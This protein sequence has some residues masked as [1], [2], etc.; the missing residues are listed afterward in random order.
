MLFFKINNFFANNPPIDGTIIV[1][2]IIPTVIMCIWN[3]GLYVYG[4]GS[5]EISPQNK[6]LT[7]HFINRK[8]HVI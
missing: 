3:G 5:E 1:H 2:F 4:T 6:G 7:N 8:E